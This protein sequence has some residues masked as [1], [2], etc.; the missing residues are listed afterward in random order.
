MV[1]FFKSYAVALDGTYHLVDGFVL[2]NNLLFKLLRHSLQADSLFLGHALNGD[3]SH[4]RHYVGH[5][6]GSYC[7]AYVDLA[8]EPFAVQL[9]Q[10]TFQYGLSVAIACCQLEV[11]VAYSL[12]LALLDMLNLLLH[13]SDF[14]WDVGILQVYA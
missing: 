11:L 3:A 8:V 9:L 6:F 2:C 10:L 14:G 5:L 7:L 1:G 4:H 13:L 12:L